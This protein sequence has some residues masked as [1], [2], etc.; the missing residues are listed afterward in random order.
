MLKF[1]LTQVSRPKVT[2]KPFDLKQ[3]IVD[4]EAELEASIYQKE[5]PKASKTA[6]G[7]GSARP[8]AQRPQESAMG[9]PSSDDGSPVPTGRRRSPQAP[10]ERSGESGGSGSRKS[11]PDTSQAGKKTS[12]PL[13]PS[14]FDLARKWDKKSFEA[15]RHGVAAKKAPALVLPPS[16]GEATF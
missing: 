3:A 5:E 8:R 1:G 2:P 13:P 15:R 12:S 9:K 4:A 14:D 7:D 6:L 11:G 16:A 10:I